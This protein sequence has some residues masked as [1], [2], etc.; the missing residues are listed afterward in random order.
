MRRFLA[1]LLAVIALA[2]AGAAPAANRTVTLSVPS[3]NCPLCP[4]TVK[5]ALS[6]VEGVSMAE[7]SYEKKEA[8]VTFDDARTSVDALRKATAEAGYPSEVKE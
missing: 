8:T 3:M 6:K 2:W 1:F 4:I 7:V 5:K